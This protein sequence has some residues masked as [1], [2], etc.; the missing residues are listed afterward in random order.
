MQKRCVN[1]VPKAVKLFI[2]ILD[3]CHNKKENSST[4]RKPVKSEKIINLSSTIWCSCP[5]TCNHDNSYNH[6]QDYYQSLLK[7]KN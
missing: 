6:S 1:K 4:Y 5:S 7:Q 3:Q 2:I